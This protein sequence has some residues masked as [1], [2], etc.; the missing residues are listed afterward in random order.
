MPGEMVLNNATN[1]AVGMIA[2]FSDPEKLI[3]AAKKMREAGYCKY[4]CHS[5]FPIHGMDKAMGLSRSKLGW[6]IGLA[7]LIGTSGGLAL[8]WWTSTIDYPLVISGKP[9]FSF[10]A[11]VPVTFA[12]GVLLGAFTALIGMMIF[13]GLPRWHHPLFNSKEFES[14]TDDTFFISVLS[15]D[16]KYDEN[17]TRQLLESIG[18][19]DCELLT[20]RGI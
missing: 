14:A 3:A 5:P 20:E 8:Q 2:R 10:Q 11:Y 13:N 4:D 15:D 1:K 18:G 19:T 17:S 6:V 7:G 9:L 16:P 12:V